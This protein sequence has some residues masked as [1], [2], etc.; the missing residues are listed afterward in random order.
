M[1]Q[2]TIPDHIALAPIGERIDWVFDLARRHAEAFASPGAWLARQRH[3]AQ[4]PTAIMV[5]KCMDGRIN[6]PVATQTPPG[7]IQPFRN[8]GGIFDL[9]WPHLGETLVAHVDKVIAAGRAGLVMIT[10]HFSKGDPARGCAGFHYRTDDARA[11][12]FQIREQ[13]RALFGGDGG[14]GDLPTIFP[15]VCGFETDADAL[16]LHGED[17]R[18]LSLADL[19]PADADSLPQRLAAL[20][21]GMPAAMRADLLPLLRGNLAHIAETR[22]QRAADARALDIEHREWMLCVG[23]GF[24]WLHT[25]NL[26]LIVG[27]YSPNLE[28]PILQAAGIVRANMEAGRIPDDGFLLLTSVPYEEIGVDRARAVLKCRFLARF[29]ADAIGRHDPDL[30]ARMT[31]RRA[32]LNWETR[33]MEMLGDEAP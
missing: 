19:S 5:L 31:L 7:I 23:R 22:W 6:I 15:L 1:P 26:A 9:G 2:R 4:H 24:D 29:A 33:A 20:L 11:H 16:V 12:T 14:G 21:P 8:L 32:V 13:V 17:G 25:P 18:T 3:L 30:A 28:G 10:Y 27:P